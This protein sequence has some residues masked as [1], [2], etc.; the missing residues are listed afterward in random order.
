MMEPLNSPL[1]AC[2][3]IFFKPNRVFATLTQKNNWSWFPFIIVTL[4]MILPTYYYF[5]FVDFDWFKEYIITAQYG[6][7]SPAE[8]ENIRR[9]MTAGTVKTFGL[10]QAGFGLIIFNAIM[11]LYLN[12]MTKS[13]EENI[14]GYTDWYG[15]TWWTAMP[16]IVSGLLSMLM[17]LLADNH[18]LSPADIAPTSLAF[19]LGLEMTSE[20]FG[21]ASSVR[22][23]SIW[24][25]YLTAVG[26][27]QWTKISQNKC[28]MIAVIP[29]A[30]IWG[31]WLVVRLV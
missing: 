25:I 13:D 17:M 12:I 20:W 31:I 9:G 14:N 3:D 15:F 22:L 4:M 6:D 18:Q 24:G 19:F 7:V 26:I 8:Q 28:W 11:A 27:S 30:L 29:S 23:E 2:N 1:Q 10:L 5:S 21:L 16:A